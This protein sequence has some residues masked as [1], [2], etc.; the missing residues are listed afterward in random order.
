[1]SDSSEFPLWQIPDQLIQVHNLIS[2]ID[3]STN[4]DDDPLGLGIT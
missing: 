3:A 1:M 4:L 2:E